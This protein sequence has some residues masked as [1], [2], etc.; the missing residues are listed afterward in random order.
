VGGTCGTY[1]G[2][3]KC[4]QGFGSEFLREETAGKTYV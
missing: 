3:E 1:G 4:F 2:E